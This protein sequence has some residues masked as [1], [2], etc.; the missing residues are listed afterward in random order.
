VTGALEIKIRGKH[1]GEQ[2]GLDVVGVARATRRRSVQRNFGETL[3]AIRRPCP[4]VQRID[5]FLPGPPGAQSAT[6]SINPRMQPAGSRRTILAAMDPRVIGIGADTR[7][8]SG[9]EP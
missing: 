6:A 8:G 1:V 4:V 9:Q 2:A 3:R 5:L 7:R